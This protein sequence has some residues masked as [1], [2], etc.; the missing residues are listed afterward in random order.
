MSAGTMDYP[1]IH[2]FSIY[3]CFTKAGNLKLSE[4]VSD[5]EIT[6][7]MYS[8]LSEDDVKFVVDGLLKAILN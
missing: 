3:K 4:Y 2:R 6:L 1:C 8:K 5:N 7:P